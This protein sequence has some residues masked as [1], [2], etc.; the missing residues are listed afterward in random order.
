MAAILVRWP[1]SFEQIVFPDHKGSIQNLTIYQAA[2]EKMFE[3]NNLSA[4]TLT[5][6]TC[7]YSCTH[8]D[9]YLYQ[10]SVQRLQ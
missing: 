6:G 3:S 9:T 10:L 7:M 5:S 1:T 2:W 4:M 8:L